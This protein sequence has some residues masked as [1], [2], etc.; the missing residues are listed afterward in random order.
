MNS[1]RSLIWSFIIGFMIAW[2]N[3]YYGETRMPDDIKIE[4]VI[5][6]EQEDNSD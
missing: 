4:I 6:N 2:H 5:D 1:I 3:V